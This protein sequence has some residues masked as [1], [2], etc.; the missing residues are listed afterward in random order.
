MSIFAFIPQQFWGHSLQVLDLSSDSWYLGTQLWDNNAYHIIYILGGPHP[1]SLNPVKVLW[2]VDL[3]LFTGSKN[4]LPLASGIYK[5]LSSKFN[6]AVSAMTFV[7]YK[8]PRSYN[9]YSNLIVWVFLMWLMMTYFLLIIW[10]K[11]LDSSIPG[12]LGFL[13]SQ[14]GCGS[15]HF[16]PCLEFVISGCSHLVR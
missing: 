5:S 11:L 13:L 1:Q 6:F 8:L 16:W 14:K 15:W 9:Y 4:K 10:S 7:F 2:W 12:C 3:G